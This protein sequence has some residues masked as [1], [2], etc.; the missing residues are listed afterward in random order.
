M[1][2]IC[3]NQAELAIQERSKPLM[4]SRQGGD[5]L[6]PTSP[7]ILII[8]DDRD[9]GDTLTDLLTQ[10]GY[11]VTAVGH[12]AEVIQ[13]VK[14]ERYGAALLNIQLANPDGLSLLKAIKELDPKLPIIVLTGDSTV[15][16]KIGV[17]LRDAFA[18]L[19]RPYDTKELTAVLRRAVEVNHFSNR[20]E[21]VERQLSEAKEQF[22]AV[23]ESASDAIVLADHRGLI[24]SW[25]RAAQLLFGHT[26]EDALGQPL[27]LIMPAR[28][29]EAH[30]KG[31]DRLRA[32]GEARIIGKTMEL[33]GLR[34][35]G[36]EF[37]LELSLG[38]WKTPS[39]IFYSGIIR[40]I[41][42]RKRAEEALRESQ[43]RFRQLAENI[44]EVFW[45]SDPEKNRIM[46]ISPGYEGIW[47]RTCESLYA[48]PRSWLEAIHPD[49]RERI[50]QAALT[51]QVTG[52]Y[53]E[54]YRIVRPNG[55]IRWIWDRAFP[56]RDASGH[57]YR[58][59]GI[60][61]DI[62]E[63]KNVE[64]QLRAS[65]ERLELAVQGSSD[66]LWDGRPLPGEPWSSLHTPGWYSPRCKAMLG[67]EEQEFENVLG[68]LIALLHPDDTERVFS[69]L[70][71]H[72]ERQEP[73]DVEYRLRTK[74]GEYRWF[75]SRGQAI[76]DEAG[77]LLRMAGSLQCIT[78]RKRAE[79]RLRAQYATMRALEESATLWEAAP[80]ILRA[81]CECLGWDFGAL[82]DMDREANALRC[83]D[84]WYGAS[85]EFAEFASVS[86]DFTFS[87]G[88]GLPGRVW[89]SGKP[90]WITNVHEDNNFPREA[91]AL[92][93]GL[94]G[95]TGF[96]ILLGD[97]TLGVIEF[98]SREVRPPDDEQIEMMAAIGGQIGQF[99]KR[100][101]HAE[102]LAKI[103]ECLLTFGKD[104]NE[105]INR[106]T[107]LCGELLGG[108]CALYRYLD[109]ELLHSIG[110]WHTPPGF[111]PVDKPNGH[112]CCDVIKQGGN[113]PLLVRHL[114]D[115]SYALTDP[116][117]I[118]YNLHTYFG[119]AV[120]REDRYV[121]ALCV[122]YQRD[123]IP[124]EGDKKFIGILASAIGVEE[125]RKK[126]DQALRQAYDETEKILASLP[127]AILI[128]NEDERIVYSNALAC[129]YFGE[130]RDMLVGLSVSE[131]LPMA[132]AR[133]SR[134]MQG[135]KPHAAESGYWQQ[136]REFQG[137]KRVYRYRLFPVAIRGSERPQTG[138]VIW[139][140]TEEKQLQDQLVQAERLASLGTLIS[141][142]AHEVN[143][144]AQ[145]ILGMAEI[146][147]E[148]TA[149]EKIK[150]FALDIVCYSQ[151]I[152][153]VVRDFV[154]YARPTVHDG[155]SE[156]DLNDRL[157]EAMRMVR[158][159]PDF[160][161]VEVVTES[162]PL[163]LIRA[164]R[165]EID[166]V[167]INLISNAVQA[168]KGQGKLTLATRLEGGS[169]VASISD[170]GCGIPKAQLQRIFDPFFTTKEPGKG[171]GL[172]LSIV[173]TIVAK[174]GGQIGVESEEGIGTTFT[175]TFPVHNSQIKQEV[176]NV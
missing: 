174:Y 140:V 103:N 151:H 92:K 43:E 136:D 38:T 96:P 102:R 155:E 152:A 15:E 31:L 88:D 165:A 67:F 81:L 144:P 50:L 115:T 112:I 20:A 128:A 16:H 49:D 35:N 141:G 108:T 65:E 13:Q 167:F 119:Q 34:K 27:T 80:K 176:P 57:V 62:T 9:I 5:A 21:Y 25:N 64:Q 78:D 163:P 76:W 29:R 137:Q 87:P 164:H 41:T 66:G 2:R 129:Q 162:Q 147:L 63:R 14:E 51:K 171:T 82:W 159:G 104:P 93:A 117:V 143:N 30:Q 113:Y 45:M 116:N 101:R 173:Y 18:C 131:V 1:P 61:E 134:L 75:R 125:G 39:G 146:I 7:M 47:G 107:A 114:Q 77:N 97:Q 122:V 23:V 59:T 52:T 166:Q 60:A 130:G 22:R 44:Q 79:Q 109:G 48:S 72:I 19:A 56:I 12:G 36:S 58:I 53:D 105:N 123:F 6:L 156:I 3:S 138:L 157:R 10:E 127:G 70:S 126:A 74:H 37:P 175:I 68:S 106:L 154:S 161:R 40:D 98:L 142:M 26:E 55:S 170:S 111:N 33:R 153:T 120:R 46:Y 89:T 85:A 8:D 145:A 90:A 168:M 84:C 121:G 91:I 149:P 17:L 160:G 83:I 28:Y 110:R 42:E 118:P 69:A 100:K 150:E 4:E 135:L 11:R 158:R 95:A 132:K 24:M 172:G 124:S 169:V 139:D 71:A 148:E 133:R 99:V 94:R 86:R 73:Y 32:T 54:E